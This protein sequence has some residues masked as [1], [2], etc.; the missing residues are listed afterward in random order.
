MRG[1]LPHLDKENEERRRIAAR[2]TAAFDGLG[3]GLPGLPQWAEAVWHLYVVRTRKRDAFAEALK[4]AGV[5]TLVHY[6][7]PPHLQAAYRDLDMD[8]SDVKRILRRFA[9][10]SPQ[11]ARTMR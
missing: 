1:K 11:L 7:I 2:Y 8:R 9:V 5:G 6:P 4:Q 10:L 3:L